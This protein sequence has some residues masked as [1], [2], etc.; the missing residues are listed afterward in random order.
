MAGATHLV[1]EVSG[2]NPYCGVHFRDEFF[3]MAGAFILGQ[4]LNFVSLAYVTNCYGEVHPLQGVAPVDN[5]SWH[6][7]LCQGF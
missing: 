2:T 6:R 5:E 7:P 3:V 1:T 4:V